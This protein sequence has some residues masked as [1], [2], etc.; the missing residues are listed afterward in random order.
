[1]NI[2]EA[3]TPLDGDDYIPTAR[4]LQQ[5]RRPLYALNKPKLIK[6]SPVIRIPERFENTV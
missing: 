2:I 6:G 1:L 3:A 4:K 5:S